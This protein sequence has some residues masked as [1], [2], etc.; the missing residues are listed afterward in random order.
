MQRG[1]VIECEQHQQAKE[2]V[3][4]DV[5]NFRIEKKMFG[6]S[7]DNGGFD[8]YELWMFD[9]KIDG[10]DVPFRF[11]LD[12]YKTIE[13]LSSISPVLTQSAIKQIEG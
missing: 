5:K 10:L 13:R 9:V 4:F 1:Y 12:Q 11:M 8:Y 3:L 2:R 6:V 7:F